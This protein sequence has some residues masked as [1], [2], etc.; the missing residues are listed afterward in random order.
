[1]VSINKNG[2]ANIGFTGDEMKN[3]EALCGGREN[4]IFRK[5]DRV[6]RPTGDWTPYVHDFLNFLIEKGFTIVP[7][8]FGINE[9]GE[10]IL[11]FVQGAVYNDPLP[12]FMLQDNMI[13]SSAKLLRGYHE[14]SGTYIDKLT[15]EEVWMLPSV[16]PIEVMCHGDFAPYNVTII[17]GEATGIIDFDTLHPGPKMW[18]IAYAVYRWVPFVNPVNPDCSFSLEEQIRKSRLFLDTYGVKNEERDLLPQMMVD[19]LTNLVNYMRNQADEGNEDFRRNI[20]EGHMEVYLKDI[21]YILKNE[22]M[23]LEGIK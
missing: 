5:S 3:N 12:E 15:K 11:S 6:V 23:I 21:Q 7:Q 8:P 22:S 13:K 4:K 10:E 1:M 18:D 19:R 17:E 9:K 20:E 14:V 16:N 2:E